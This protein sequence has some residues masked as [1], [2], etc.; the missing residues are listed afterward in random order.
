MQLHLGHL[1][2]K[3]ITLKEADKKWLQQDPGGWINNA[4]TI[5]CVSIIK[6]YGANA[7]DEAG[8]D[9]LYFWAAG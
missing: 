9:M 8:S 6:E 7:G 2:G 5:P 4:S 3:R 1:G